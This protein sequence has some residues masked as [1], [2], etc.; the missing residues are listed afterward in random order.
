MFVMD[1]AFDLDSTTSLHEQEVGCQLN[2]N[3]NW[4]LI[5]DV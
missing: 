4:M 1:N 3:G 2:F 5:W